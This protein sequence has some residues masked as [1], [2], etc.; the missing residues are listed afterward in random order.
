MDDPP[1]A[2]PPSGTPAANPGRGRVALVTGA[3]KGLGRS[4]ALH[5]AAAGHRVI[6]NFFSSRDDA[7]ALVAEIR[8]SGGQAHCMGADVRDP[9]C[10]AALFA[11]ARRVF[12]PVE[13]VVNNATGPQPMK[14][15]EAYAWQEY[16]DQLDYFVKAPV[17]IA[18]AALADMKQARWGRIIQIGSEVVDLGSSSYSAYVAAKA[19][20]VGLTRAWATE[21]GPWGITVNLVAPG[22]IPVE[23]HAGMAKSAF[24][25]YLHGVPLQRQGT[26]AEVAGS[27]VYLAGESAGFVTGQCLA[28]NGGNTF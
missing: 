13:I 19:A 9:A 3:S 14:A 17:L 12:G 28:V 1:Q 6:V 24:A 26:P 23:R 5:L 21:L 15:I 20:L 18:Q 8:E 10:V 7:A 16:Q 4:I 25:A 2:I 11:E 22:W 27:V